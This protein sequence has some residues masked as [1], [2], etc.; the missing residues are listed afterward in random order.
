MEQLMVKK[1]RASFWK[2]GTVIELHHLISKDQWW[3][4][5]TVFIS[6]MRAKQID[7][8]EW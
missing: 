5:H 4:F 2:E 7:K 1:G 8:S 6:H 3:K